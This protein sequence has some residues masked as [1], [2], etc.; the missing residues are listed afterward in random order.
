MHG[1]RRA[2]AEQCNTGTILPLHGA[3]IYSS[4]DSFCKT[5]VHFRLSL[6][7]VEKGRSVKIIKAGV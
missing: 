6:I 5:F 1:F 4:S 3:A 2:V 7:L